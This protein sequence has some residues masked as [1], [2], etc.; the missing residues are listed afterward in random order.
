MYS[1]LCYNYPK[2]TI[3]SIVVDR[4]IWQRSWKFKKDRGVQIVDQT[5]VVRY[6]AISKSGFTRIINRLKIIFS[7]NT[8][9]KWINLRG[10]SHI[11]EIKIIGWTFL[12]FNPTRLDKTATQIF[13][14]WE[15]V[16]RFKD[17]ELWTV[18][19]GWKWPKWGK[20]GYEA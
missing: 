5:V 19:N 20:V 6:D 9:G 12:D 11:Y 8:I 1:T 15:W 18:K 10:L 14:W 4:K 16:K 17:F 3:F 2:C 7:I 13:I